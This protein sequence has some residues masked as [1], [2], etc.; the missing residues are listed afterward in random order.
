MKHYA[1]LILLDI[2]KIK[3]LGTLLIIPVVLTNTLLN[4]KQNIFISRELHI[5]Y[6][7]QHRQFSILYYKV[8]EEGK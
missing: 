6:I 8:M 2:Y 5:S 7:I 1:L 3:A 4:V